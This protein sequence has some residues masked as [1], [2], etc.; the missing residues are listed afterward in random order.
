M[1]ALI[2]CAFG[3]TQPAL[4]Q[5]SPSKPVVKIDETNLDTE[6][7]LIVGSNERGGDNPLP[8][9]LD[10]VS[11]QLHAILPFKNYNLVA[12]LLNRVKNDGR[13]ELT[14]IGGS[15][16]AP[17]AALAYRPT[18]SQ[19]SIGHVRLVDSDTGP[20]VQML[21]FSYGA[22]FPIQTATTMAASGNSV[23][24][25]EYQNTGLT[26]D[27]SIKPDEP[28]IVGT[29]NVGPSGDALIIVVSARRAPK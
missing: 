4:G 1:F 27:I 18:F 14:W 2:V 8:T 6:L 29:L 12:T 17:N 11:K 23:P 13:L 19:F 21:R 9:S 26:T 15:L 7:Y 24:Q 22:R 25:F 3:V 16:L 28:G 10:K 20:V 5:D